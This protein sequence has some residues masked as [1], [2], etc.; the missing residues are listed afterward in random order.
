[1]TIRASRTKCGLLSPL[2]YSIGAALCAMVSTPPALAGN[3]FDIGNGGAVPMDT[4]AASSAGATLPTQSQTKLKLGLDT[5]NREYQAFQAA[6]AQGLALAGAFATQKTT[7]QIEDNRVAID[8]VASDDTIRLRQALERLGAKITGVAGRMVS[9]EVPLA[10]IPAL[11][12]VQALQFARLSWA[13]TR[14]GSVT[15]Q[16]DP[17]Q[18]SDL[19][20]QDSGVDGSGSTVGV[21]SDS[22]NCLRTGTTYAADVLSGDLPLGVLV[23]ADMRRSCADEGR[24]MAQIVY[25]VA[26]GAGLAFH[27]AF[28]GEA[29]F[30]QGILDLANAG[31]DIIVDD[32]IYFAEPMFQ[33]GVIAQAVDQVNAMGIPYFSAAGNTG[34]DAYQAAFLDSGLT[35]PLGGALHDFDP[36]PGVDTRLALT[37]NANTT[38]ILQWQDPFFSVSGFPG[39]TTDLNLCVYSP[40]GAVT[41][42]ACAQDANIGGDPLEGL[43]LRGTQNLEISIEK[44]SGPDP[45]PIKLVMFGDTTPVDTYAGIGAGTIYGHANAVGANA[46][47]ASAYFLTPEFGENP[48]VLNY[49]SSA[50]NTPILFDTDGSPI[51]ETREKPEFTAPDGGNNTFFGSDF[52]PDG[53][54]NFFGTSAAAPHA[55]GVAALMREVDPTLTPIEVTQL[56]QGTAVDI[57]ERETLGFFGPR[58]S[59]DSGYD[60][61]SGA[62]LIDAL[63]ALQAIPT[64]TPTAA[65]L[66]ITKT[67]SPDPATVGAQLTYTIT[68]TNLGPSTATGVTM[69]DRLPLRT[70]FVSVSTTQGTCS[71]TTTVV[72]NLSSLTAGANAIVEIVV[73]PPREGWIRNQAS[74]EAVEPDPDAANNIAQAI[75]RVGAAQ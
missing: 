6:T 49:Y 46:V 68:V 26:P 41:P 17:A 64:S 74:V 10:R 14:T 25:D 2:T 20:R 11:E 70:T 9:A 16:G 40:P 15:S 67:D 22:F 33:D 3:V 47:G 55:A 8:A 69:T 50:G 29:D 27:T 65:D 42:V 59:L 35:G 4:F 71:G 45:D 7:A 19:A 52:E 30:A 66:S 5:L 18:R 34:R 72:C 62:G 23:L 28:N 73:K 13:T 24:A 48:P 21:L 36:G 56:L 58:V 38:Y 57:V 12:N 44:S 31:A 60:N 43:S 1:M 53:W 37:Q 75:T 32:V 61:D 54:P 39:A 63:A 51:S